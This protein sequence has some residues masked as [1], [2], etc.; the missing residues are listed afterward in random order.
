MLPTVSA[1]SPVLFLGSFQ[2][3]VTL[4]EPTDLGNVEPPPPPPGPPC[5]SRF[6][7]ADIAATF[8]GAWNNPGGRGSD[9]VCGESDH[10]FD[11]GGSNLCFGGTVGS[12]ND[13]SHDG[14]AH[15]VVICQAIG[16]RLC[17][18]AEL[19]ADETRGSGCGHDGEMT[20]SST[21]CDGGMTT[22]VGG[23]NNANARASDGSC[24]S[25]DNCVGCVAADS[26]DPA[27]RC[28]GTCVPS[29]RSH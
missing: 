25:A 17:T 8:G 6:S 1:F 14:Y 26:T 16:A 27:V 5:T 2:L 11:E 4:S 13:A 18:A 10:G 7:C 29:K 3:Y 20:W 21:P 28:C 19:L 12:G 15:A 24:E 23:Q 22:A 9:Q